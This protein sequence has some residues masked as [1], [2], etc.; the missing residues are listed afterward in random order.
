MSQSKLPND[1]GAK[2]KAMTNA[3]LAKLNKRRYLKDR[4]ANWT[5]IGGGLAVLASVLLIFV[6]LLAESLPLF[7]GNTADQNSGFAENQVTVVHN[8]LL[9]L[10]ENG[11]AGLRLNNNQ[12]EMIDMASGKVMQTFATP[13]P[14]GVVVNTVVTGDV[15]EQNYGL[16]LSN[17]GLLVVKPEFS[18]RGV[19]KER[20]VTAKI[21]YPFG[22]QPMQVNPVGQPLA[23]FALHT[24]DQQV[25]VITTS[26]GILTTHWFGKPPQL[27]GNAAPAGQ[28]DAAGEGL[29]LDMAALGFDE[30]DVDADVPPAALAATDESATDALGLDLSALGSYDTEEPTSVEADETAEQNTTMLDNA[31]QDSLGLDL[32][33]LGEYESGADNVITEAPPIVPAPAYMAAVQFNA[34]AGTNITQLFF[35]N[36]GAYVFVVADGNVVLL[37]NNGENWLQVDQLKLEKS[38]AITAAS[39]LQGNSS[40]LLGFAN[41]QVKQ[42]FTSKHSDSDGN[43]ESKIAEVR[44]FKLANAPITLLQAEV[45]RKGFM[46]ADSSGNIGYFYTT[47]ARKVF[48]FNN[49]EVGKVAAMS[50][51]FHDNGMW[52][53]GDKGSAFYQVHA[54]HP[55][56]S[57]SSLW[58]KV[59]YESYK[60]PAYA[61]QS[62]S[63]SSDFESKMS[64]VPLTFGTIKAAIWTMLLAAPLALAAAAYTAAFMAPKLRTVVKPT[65]ELMQALPTVI[66]GFLAGLWLAPIISSH[67]SAV[68]ALLVVLPVVVLLLGY[69]WGYMPNRIK[70]NIADGYRPLLLVLPICLA[71]GLTFWLAP[72]IETQLFASTGGTL[73]GF[74]K[75]QGVDY[76]AQNALIV[77]L[78]MG[79]AVI[80]PIYSIAEDAIFGVPKHL[81]NGSLALGATPWQ[82]LMRVSILTAAPGIFSALMIGF[83]RAVGE[84]MIVLMA[85]GN[86]AIMDMSLFNGMRTLSANVAVEM[87]EAEVASTHYRVLFLSALVLLVLTFVLNTLAEVVRNNLR[88]KYGSL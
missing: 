36:Q 73:V 60:E 27:E 41:G 28:A 80:A 21:T 67:L 88:K 58:G 83:G 18:A 82:T 57:L 49:P 38:N 50:M 14:A 48:K 4:M 39:M 12:F 15:I 59:W 5:I 22:T 9:L 42:L 56:V 6:Y 63:A 7:V 81:V 17:G 10:E 72:I 66:L 77:G 43:D 25:Q 32:A 8:P 55:D 85:T 74:L 69:S 35:A 78:M 46:A 30:E 52:L 20:V 47:S 19:G 62:T 51:S 16:G 71:L 23:G 87:G 26:N 34:L 2:P 13:I 75:A 86:T 45:R 64:L 31:E 61:W 37:K 84:T 53:V 65:I 29:S 3:A 24:A 70:H 68:F 76:Q 54:E 40:L 44:S 1:K 33:A 79:F 11:Q